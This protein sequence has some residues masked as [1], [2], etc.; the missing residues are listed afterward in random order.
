MRV[1]IY[2][3]FNKRNDSPRNKKKDEK[4]LQEK[5]EELES[6]PLLLKHTHTPL[7]I[8][9]IVKPLAI[10]KKKKKICYTAKLVDAITVSKVK[11]PLITQIKKIH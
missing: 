10:M 8:I 5:N 4:P 2:K 9:V 3:K 7:I 6:P 11:N 1:T